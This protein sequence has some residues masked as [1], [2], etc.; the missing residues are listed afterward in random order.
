MREA[1]MTGSGEEEPYSLRCARRIW[2]RPERIC[3]KKMQN[4]R[5]W[6]AGGARVHLPFLPAVTAAVGSGEQQRREAVLVDA[7]E[8][9]LGCNKQ[10]QAIQMPPA[11]GRVHGRPQVGAARIVDAHTEVNQ[12]LEHSSLAAVASGISEAASYTT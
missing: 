12:L 1:W 5:R 2:L 11:G 7:I 9:V 8:W 6:A 4:V 10:P 3:C